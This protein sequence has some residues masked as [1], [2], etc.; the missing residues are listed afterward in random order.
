MSLLTTDYNSGSSDDEN[1]GGDFEERESLKLSN[2]A[3][4]SFEV[5]RLNQ[6]T[7]SQY[8]QSVFV[9]VDDVRV[10]HGLVYDRFHSDD[11][12]T[13]KIFGFGK[14]FK[15]N[16]DGTLAEDVQD[17]LLNKRISEEFG[18][19]EYPYELDGYT[20]EDVD[21]EI[22]MGDMSMSLSNSTKY[23]TFLKVIT[24]AGHD[25]IDDKDDEYNWAD[26]N[27]LELRD[28]I[29]GRRIVLFYKLNTFTPDGDDEEVTYTDAVILD[30]ETGAGITIQNGSSSSSSSSSS[31]STDTSGGTVGGDSGL[32]DGVPEAADDIVDFLA[33]TGE[34]DRDSI[35]DL[36]SGEADEYDLDAVVSEVERRMD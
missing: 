19:K 5:S 17:D 8:G 28:D 2:Y 22:E 7:G 3:I 4:I 23:R 16:A 11:D 20:T 36:V 29:L 13:M 12:D 10:K 21:E 32:P 35:D 14:W 25:V 6:Y 15:T 33:R 27:E 31:T 24:K 26:E 18:G 30:E 9:D 34:T 1:S